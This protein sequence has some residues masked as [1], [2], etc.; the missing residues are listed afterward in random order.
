MCPHH[1]AALLLV[2]Q[3]GTP[4]VRFCTVV[5]S[6]NGIEQRFLCLKGFFEVTVGATWLEGLQ[7]ENV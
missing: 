7:E 1:R 6:A 5:G 3:I 2:T 4:L